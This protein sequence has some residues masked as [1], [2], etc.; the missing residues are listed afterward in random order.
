MRVISFSLYGDRP[1][2]LKGMVENAKLAAKFYPGW[3]IR[4]YCEDSINVKPLEALGCQIHRVGKSFGH[5]GMFWR[6]LP[7]WDK[8]VSY[9]LFRDADSRL[10]PRASAAVAAWIDSGLACHAMH[11]HQHHRSIPIL[12]GMWGIMGNALPSWLLVRCIEVYGGHAEKGMDSA[13]LSREIWP[14]VRETCLTHSSVP[15]AFPEHPIVIPPQP[16]PGHAPMDGFVGQ[17]Y[18]DNGQPIWPGGKP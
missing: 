18:D 15:L 11:D 10:N 2:Y 9:C 13:Y 12:G 6:F 3:H 8:G 4:V 14:F 16:F 17:Q 1:M 7:A 5:S